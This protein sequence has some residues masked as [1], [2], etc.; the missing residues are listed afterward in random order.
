MIERLT[1]NWHERNV[2]AVAIKADAPMSL[3][4]TTKLSLQVFGGRGG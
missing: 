1:L 3:A 4:Q 2:E